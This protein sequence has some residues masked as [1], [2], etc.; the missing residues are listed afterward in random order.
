L[1]STGLGFAEA[2]QADVLGSGS[3][4]FNWK[5]WEPSNLQAQKNVTA[6]RRAIWGASML[7]F[8][9]VSAVEVRAVA[10]RGSTGLPGRVARN[11]ILPI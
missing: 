6:F 5:H 2:D 7:G 3:A 4:R 1:R 10:G 8:G 11:V 9:L